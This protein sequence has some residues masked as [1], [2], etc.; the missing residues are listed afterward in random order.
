MILSTSA[1]LTECAVGVKGGLYQ[2]SLLTHESN[3]HS[4]MHSL[5]SLVGVFLILFWKLLEI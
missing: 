1:E 2:L 4:F 3:G 5:L